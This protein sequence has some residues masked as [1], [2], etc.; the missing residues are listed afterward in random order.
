MNSINLLNTLKFNRNPKVSEHPNYTRA[1]RGCRGACR[2]AAALCAAI[3]DL[4]KFWERTN[5]K[6][7][8]ESH[9]EGTRGPVRN[10]HRPKPRRRHC[11]R[12]GTRWTACPDRPKTHGYIRVWSVRVLVGPPCCEGA[13][14]PA[15]HRHA[16][17]Q[18]CGHGWIEPVDTVS[19]FGGPDA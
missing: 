9:A 1:K 12:C 14:V 11:P 4:K 5:G 8:T 16:G 10:L 17:C 6:A 3:G 7:Q 18:A 13:T 19:T 15:D 2:S